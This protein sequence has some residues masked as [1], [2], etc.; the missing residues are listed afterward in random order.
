MEVAREGGRGEGAQRCG[1]LAEESGY[2][3][4]GSGGEETEVGG[5]RTQ[6]P[7]RQPSRTSSHPTSQRPP[8]LQLQ[9]AWKKGYK[10]PHTAND[11]TYACMLPD[12]PCGPAGWNLSPPPSLSSAPLG[13]TV[14]PAAS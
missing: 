14:G 10:R 2:E 4:E 13:L 8:P 11:A 3:G 7:R 9:L 5:T 1:E 12:F 6:N